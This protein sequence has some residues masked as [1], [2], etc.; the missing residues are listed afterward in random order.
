M[1]GLLKK[2]FLCRSTGQRVSTN[3]THNHPMKKLISNREFLFIWRNRT[4]KP[5]V[6]A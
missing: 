2:S 3:T 5:K 1:T 4:E 6:E